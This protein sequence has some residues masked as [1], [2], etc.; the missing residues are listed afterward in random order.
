MDINRTNRTK[1]NH[2]LGVETR[3]RAHAQRERESKRERERER[4][5]TALRRSFGPG[6]EGLSTVSPQ[7]SASFRR[8]H[9][10][11]GGRGDA[12]DYMA[13]LILSG[14]PPLIMEASI[15]ISAALAACDALIAALSAAVSVTSSSPITFMRRSDL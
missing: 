3:R 10:G 8:C 12:R 11:K 2:D 15:P 4:E 9:V 14:M 13:S 5:S 6:A 7:L 1:I